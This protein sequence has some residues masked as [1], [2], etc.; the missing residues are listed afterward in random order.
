MKIQE[1]R[2]YF[3]LFCMLGFMAG[4]LYANVLS[5]DY[6]ASMGIFS[7]F[8]LKQYCQ[9]EVNI[10]EFLWYILRVRA[11]PLIFLG[12]TGCTRLRKPVVILFLTWTGFSCGMVMTAAVMQMGIKGIIL[13]LVGLMPHVLFYV[14]G[15][16]ML[17]WFLFCYPQIKWDF[18]K[19]V[20]FLLLIAVGIVLECYVNPALMKMFLNTL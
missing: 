13:C 11:A 16:V 6:I 9:T 12:I 8:F 5:G 20:C 15:Y 2:K 1:N 7:D 19:A 14:A 17:L 10:S 3:V 18:M 4:I